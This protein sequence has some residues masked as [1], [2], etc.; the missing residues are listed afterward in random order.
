MIHMN[1]WKIV[2]CTTVL[3][4][5]ARGADLPQPTPV[6]PAEAAKDKA[7]D[8]AKAER[9]AT[10]D[11]ESLEPMEVAGT[12]RQGPRERGIELGL[13]VRVYGGLSAAYTTNFADPVLRKDANDLRL[14]DRDHDSFTPNALVGLERALSGRNAY[15][16][17]FR[18][19][20]GVGRLMET[21]LASDGLFDG[22]PINLPQ[23]YAQAQLPTPWGQP[24]ALKA[25][26]WTFL[27]G[28][29]GLDLAANQTYSIGY[30]ATFG[31]KTLTGASLTLRLAPG[32]EYEQFV[33]NGWDEVVDGNDAKTVGGLLT[34][35]AGAF[36]FRGG[37][38]LG[39]ERPGSVSDHRW[40]INAD[41]TWKPFLGT[42][43]RASFVY[44]EEEGGNVVDGGLARF[45][46]I[47]LG[48]RQGL[49]QVSG[50]DWYRLALV[51]RGDV[52]R[53]DGGSRS[54]EDQDLAQVTGGIEL[55]FLRG[56]SVRAEYRHDW[57]SQDVFAG[58]DQQQT[59]TLSLNVLF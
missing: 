14:S 37:W 18:L 48:F 15:D 1:W 40:A 47:G 17:G 38:I 26:R 45:G 41:A 7:K 59:L 28:G 22:E 5:T 29:D 43:L 30:L 20:L 6:R 55:Q 19:E 4:A 23:F 25:G 53:D 3:A 58:E 9:T 10:T 54:G 16:A 35:D 27:H 44:G 49:F 11:D 31:P 32:L 36:M 51:G 8:K 24:V 39:A 21:A 13:G 57:S 52:F 33:A 42:E 46:G 12:K 56:A 34:L 50:E 2:L